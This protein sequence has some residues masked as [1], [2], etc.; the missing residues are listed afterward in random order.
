MW[1][2]DR[3]KFL[4]IIA[5]C[6]VASCGF[7]PALGPGG[8]AGVLRGAIEIADPFDAA[9]FAFVR[10]L[11][12]R[13]GPAEAPRYRLDAE[14][15]VTD[16]GV[17]ILPDQTTTRY[18]LA[19]VADYRLRGLDDEAV[20]T[21]G[22]VANFTSYSATSTTV[23]T[24]AAERDARERLMVALADQLVADLMLTRDDWAR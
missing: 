23:A 24:A 22:R 14:I 11:E 4:T 19:G 7:S 3:R 1:S 6:G 20:L 5:A 12:R 21:T 2:S 10:Q 18:Q 13:L 17:G 8:G 15:R 16:D 9:G